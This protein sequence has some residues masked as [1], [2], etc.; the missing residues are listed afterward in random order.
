MPSLPR[1]TVPGLEVQNAPKLLNIQALRGVAALMVASFHGLFY[2]FGALS[3][4][5]RPQWTHCGA[6]GVDLF[7]V[8]S[9]FIMVYVNR[10]RFGSPRHQLNFLFD[11]ATRIYPAYWIATLPVIAACLLLAGEVNQSL[12]LRHLASSIS[13]WPAEG[14]FPLLRVGWSLTHEVYFY[15][16]FSFFLLGRRSALLAKLL[17]WAAAVIV[18]RIA[19]PAAWYQLPLLRL[20]FNPFTLEFITGALLAL[21]VWS[22]RWNRLGPWLLAGGFVLMMA[23]TL[24]MPDPSAASSEWR[25]W[26]FGIPSLMIVGGAGIMERNGQYLG[27]LQ[28]LGDASFQ[29][30]LWHNTVIAAVWRFTQFLPIPNEARLALALGCGISAGCL[31]H[32]YIERPLLRVVRGWRKRPAAQDMGISS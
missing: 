11:R 26:Y 27:F 31:A 28:R 22:G 18:L 10:D 1:E 3:G 2:Y 19:L 32:R 13:L 24:A 7:F 29:I 30:Y 6:A 8:I 4:Q 12:T 25:P 16:V 20:A 9:G 14:G 15:I 23:G 17:G 5:P 21:A